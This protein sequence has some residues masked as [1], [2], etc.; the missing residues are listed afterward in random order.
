MDPISSLCAEIGMPEE[1]TKILSETETGLPADNEEKLI[2][3]LTDK[4]TFKQA[5]DELRAALPQDE[6]GAIRGVIEKQYLSKLARGETEKVVAA[7]ARRGF[8]AREARAAV[9]EFLSDPET[10]GD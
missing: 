9:A 4:A 7:L 1:V 2:S 3:A 8:S 10:A 5:A 6:G